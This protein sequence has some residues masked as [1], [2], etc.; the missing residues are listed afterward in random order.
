MFLRFLIDKI[1]SLYKVKQLFVN[2]VSCCHHLRNIRNVKQ[3]VA[4]HGI[5][6]GP[7]RYHSQ[8]IPSLQVLRRGQIG[9][10]EFSPGKKVFPL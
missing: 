5:L 9:A 8:I 1:L 2:I 6:R 10:Q 4:N 7:T 3:G